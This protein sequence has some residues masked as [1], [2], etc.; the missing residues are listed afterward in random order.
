MDVIIL[1]EQNMQISANNVLRTPQYV[2]KHEKWKPNTW[3]EPVYTIHYV[4]KVKYIVQFR[5]FT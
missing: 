5:H 3:W 4:E 2:D 1:R